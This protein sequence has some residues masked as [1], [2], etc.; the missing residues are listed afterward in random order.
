MKHFDQLA[1]INLLNHLDFPFSEKK[2]QKIYS[3]KDQKENKDLV[4]YHHILYLK[5]LSRKSLP[6]SRVFVLRWLIYDA[7]SLYK[8][9][10]EHVWRMTQLNLSFYEIHS[11]APTS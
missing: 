11:H 3:K 10:V 5:F 9:I 2:N 6:V 4:S 7:L 8:M 1:L